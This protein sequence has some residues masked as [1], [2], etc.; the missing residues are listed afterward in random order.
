V[1]N[2]GDEPSGSGAR[3]YS[4]LGAQT[5]VDI[6]GLTTATQQINAFNAS[7]AQLQTTLTKLAASAP[8]AASTISSSVSKVGSAAGGIMAGVGNIASSMFG[9]VGERGWARDLAMFPSRYMRSNISENRQL[10]LTA[11]AG[12]APLA[13]GTGA[14]T[15]DM[16]R[17]LAGQLGNVLGGSPADLVNLANAAN[18]YGAGLDFRYYGNQANPNTQNPYALSNSPRAGGFLRGVYEAQRISP[19][20]DVGTLAAAIGGYAGNIGAQQQSAFLTGGAFSMIAAGNRQKSISEW[21]EGI[22]KWLQ[23]LRPGGKRGQAFNYAELM[24]QNFPGSNIDAWLTANGVSEDMKTFFWAYALRTASTG[25][26]TTDEL[27]RGT[28]LDSNVAYQRLQAGAAQTRTGFQLAGQMGGAYAN[29]EQANRFFAEMSGQ[30]MNQILPAAMSGGVLSYMQYLPDAIE[31]IIMQLAERTNVGTA[32]AGVAGWGSLF[33]Q[34]FG[35]DGGDLGDVGDY[36]PMGGTTTAG[37][38][39]DMRKRVDAMMNANPRLRVTS[40]FRDLGTQQRLK[41][42]GVGRVSGRPSAHTRGMAA[43]LGPRSEYGWISRNAGRF[44]LKS[45]RGQGEPWHVGMGDVGD[46]GLGGLLSAG[47]LSDAIG[48]LLGGSTAG[49]FSNIFNSIFGSIFKGGNADDQI[50]GVGSASSLLMQLILGVFGGGQANQM[51]LAYRDVYSGLV[52]AANGASAAGLSS[53]FDPSSVGGNWFQKIFNIRPLPNTVAAPGTSTGT[54]PSV[55]GR[56]TLREFF[57]SVL[58]GLGAPVS[59]NNLSKLGTVAKYEGTRAAYNPF[60]SRGG[61]DQFDWFNSVGVVNY[62]D[63]NTGVEW[64]IRLLNQGNT[65]QMKANLMADASYGNWVDRTAAF[66]TWADFPGRVTQSNGISKLSD[67]VGIGDIA[68]YAM[69]A[70]LSLGAGAARPMV[71]Y[72]SFKIDG[73]GAGGG[74][75]DVRRTATLLAD[76]LEDQMKRRQSR[77]N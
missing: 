53:G 50:K 64:L 30:L 24:S 62:P 55:S 20:T 65:A 21:A 28:A 56:P 33:P 7:I 47:G 46:D 8:T 40:G 37:L 54:A 41:R 2:T 45:G 57:S 3:A 25:H 67:Q 58:T 76:Q 42:K 5:T 10:A 61:R 74:G 18:R 12:L 1:S 49:A 26:S 13:F 22:L 36:G 59:E 16:M 31:E 72:N 60:G 27:F 23:N 71:F 51:N 38:H 29:K 32:A 39:P 75:L 15:Q 69:P 52:A 4:A 68:D 6:Q 43:D 63:A 9:A 34:L 11:S 44:G 14:S 70:A 73:S 19:G 66:Y 17:A 48:S 35:G 77:S